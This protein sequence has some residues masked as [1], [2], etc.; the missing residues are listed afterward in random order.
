MRLRAQKCVSRSIFAPGVVV[1]RTVV[2]ASGVDV[3]AAV[4]VARGVVVIAARTSRVS[5]AASPT[6]QPG[7]GRTCLRTV[8]T[9][10]AA[11]DAYE[12]LRMLDL[13]QASSW[14][15]QSWWALRSRPPA[16]SR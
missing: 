12:S 5:V 4:E 16:A 7:L 8:A 13:H 2:V 9:R 1:G 14:T 10:F 11:G 3:G 6:L 15:A